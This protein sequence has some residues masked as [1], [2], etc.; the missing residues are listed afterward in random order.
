[1]S[2]VAILDADKEGF[3]RSRTSLVQTMGRAA[4]HVEGQVIMYADRVTD[5][6]RNAIDEVN[7]RREYQIAYNTEHHITPTSIQKAIRERIV[8]K[9]DDAPIKF[10]PKQIIRG[11]I[12]D[13]ADVDMSKVEQLL[14]A[15]M[16][17]LVKIM[18]RQMHEAAKNLDFE[19]AARI[20]DRL[21]DIKSL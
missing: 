21:Q 6:M 5:S 2:L 8:E 1:V 15:D 10:D 4:R 9:T 19:T 14:P 16:T 11:K 7:R 20:R 17:K 12:T 3:L 18:T 13:A